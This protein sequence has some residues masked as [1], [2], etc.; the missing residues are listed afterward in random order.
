[1]QTLFVRIS[2]EILAS[3]KNST[4]SIMLREVANSFNQDVNEDYAM[5]LIANLIEC[6][7]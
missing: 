1:M 2:Y 3:L 7:G 6:T 4:F 5:S